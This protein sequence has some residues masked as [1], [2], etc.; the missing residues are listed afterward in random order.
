MQ[1]LPTDDVEY[2]AGPEGVRDWVSKVVDP[3]YGEHVRW[4]STYRFHQVVADSYTDSHHR[5]LLAGEA[6]HLFAP[7]GGRGLNSGVFDA[8]DAAT[9][10]GLASASGDETRRREVIDRW[11]SEGRRWGLHNRDISSKALRQMRGSD[12]VNH[13]KREVAS[14]LAPIV[15]PAGA[16]LANGPLQVPVP[17]PGSRKFY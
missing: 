12:P 15:W 11:A 1:C 17:R 6:A 16:W 3:W 9:A 5:V 2:L 4:V 13:V 14:R 7:W 8:T 10:I